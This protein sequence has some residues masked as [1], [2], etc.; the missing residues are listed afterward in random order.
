[1]NEVERLQGQVAALARRVEA[2]ESM[3]RLVQGSGAD[4]RE[5]GRMVLEV[6]FP[7]EILHLPSRVDERRTVALRLRERGWSQ[8]RIARVMG[9]CEKTV[10]RWCEN[11]N[12]GSPH[13]GES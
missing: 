2:L 1:M 5:A 13:Q 12:P 6:G 7:V 11:A 8:A 3:L 4:A 9:C 10:E